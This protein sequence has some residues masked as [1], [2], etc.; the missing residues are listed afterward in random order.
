MT[1]PLHNPTVGQVFSKNVHVQ[2]TDVDGLTAEATATVQIHIVP[3]DLDD[4]LPPICHV[5][6]WLPQ[7]QP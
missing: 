2:V 5:K 6:P 3:A 4:G 7:C 1:F